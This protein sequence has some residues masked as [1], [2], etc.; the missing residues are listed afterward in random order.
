[1][2]AMPKVSF[3]SDLERPG[4]NAVITTLYDMVEAVS[5]EVGPGEDRLVAEIVLDL[6]G[7]ESTISPFQNILFQEGL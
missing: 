5:E 6:L 3:V 7:S 2:Q 4:S 1:M